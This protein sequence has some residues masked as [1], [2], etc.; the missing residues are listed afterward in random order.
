MIFRNMILDG[1]ISQD[2]RIVFV[3]DGSSDKTWRLISDLHSTW[4]VIEGLKLAHNSG[5]MNALW[6]GLNHACD[7]C[8][9]VITIDADLQDDPNVI[10][11]FVER[12][13]KG[14]DV[15]YGVRSSR[16]KDSFF[17]RFTAQMFYK[18]MRANGVPLVYDHADY[19]LLSSRAL[20]ALLDFEEVN[21]FLRGIVPML[22]FRT[23]TVMYDREERF[24][25]KSK[26]PLKKM[27]AFAME[28]ITSLSN[29]PLHI[30]AWLGF[31]FVLISI[32]LSFVLK[33]F[34]FSVFSIW[35]VSGVVLMMLGII[36]EYLGKI[37]LE[38][39]HR[40]RFIIERRLLSKPEADEG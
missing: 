18:M 40:P 4:T 38:T 32:V 5:H 39:K 14:F 37:Y 28:G 23:S 19:R 16:K 6:A 31:L 7:R 22:G 12:Y 26:Y 11:E 3:D 33:P 15:V 8:D 30:S 20:Y 36:G 1:R 25:G 21:M 2:S 35:F 34:E 13:R 27:I 24:A 10:P 9:C 17:K 29:K